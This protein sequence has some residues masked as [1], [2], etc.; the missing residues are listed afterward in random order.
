[1]A[2][3]RSVKPEFWDDRKLAR[4]VSRDG[5][6]L[7]IG[8]WNHSDEHARV[9][10]D[11][12]LIKGRVFPYEDDL[13]DEAVEELLEELAAAGRIV[14]YVADGDPY[15]FLPKLSKHQRLEAAKVPSRLPAPEDA[16]PPEPDSEPPA[17]RAHESARGS[18]EAARRESNTRDASEGAREG[19]APGMQQPQ[20]GQAAAAEPTSGTPTDESDLDQANTQVNG[21]A[22]IGADESARG[23][24]ESGTTAAF[25]GSRWQ[26]AGGREQ[27]GAGGG[28]HAVDSAAQ[29]DP[30]VRSAHESDPTTKAVITRER[31]ARFAEF[32]DAYPRKVGRKAAE[33]KF[34]TAVK[35]V[36]PQVI[37]D[38][39]H[40]FA[41]AQ[42]RADPKFIPHP[43]TWLHQ[44]RWDDEDEPAQSAARNGRQPYRNQA[45]QGDPDPFPQAGSWSMH[46]GGTHV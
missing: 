25:A 3:I 6:L 13:D 9:Q 16:D 28:S 46:G 19:S 21:S 43:A 33:Q 5:R 39:A 36:D 8:L 17:P 41:A 35:T 27:G 29:E 38:A 37:I 23:A 31:N 26:V 14:R 42:A 30:G 1:M 40:R 11:A 12:R 2:R 34:R 10:G 18:D 20:S 44:G 45:F 22:Q 24:D 15:L 32:Y 7:Y 4:S